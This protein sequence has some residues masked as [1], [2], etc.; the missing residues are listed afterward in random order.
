MS[1][2]ELGLAALAAFC[3]LCL[4]WKFVKFVFRLV[5]FLAFAGLLLAFAVRAGYVT[6]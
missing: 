3:V 1:P 4:A 6:V 2:T 5:L